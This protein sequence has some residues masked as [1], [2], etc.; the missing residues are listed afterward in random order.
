[1]RLTF[2]PMLHK[3]GVNMVF[4]GHV[5]AYECSYPVYNNAL[6]STGAIYVTIGDGGNR[7]GLY[8]NW[9]DPQPAT[10]RFR[11]AEYGHGELTFVS[12]TTA[13]WSWIRNVDAEPTPSD[14]LTI[15]NVAV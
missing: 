10:S 4:A 15:T 7:E 1:M 3:A 2:E 8:T 14:T 6:D 9:V 12:A 13:T 11:Q 5:H